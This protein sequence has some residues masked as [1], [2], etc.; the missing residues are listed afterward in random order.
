MFQDSSQSV[1]P[2]NLEVDENRDIESPNYYFILIK[3]VGELTELWS[4]PAKGRE[5]RI[6]STTS[7]LSTVWEKAFQTL[8][9]DR[10]GQRQ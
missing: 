1:E 9:E 7:L 8:A 4:T 6:P 2:L 3:S 10:G 5:G